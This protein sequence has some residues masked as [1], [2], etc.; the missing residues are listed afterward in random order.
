MKP[1]SRTINE[2]IDLGYEVHVRHA[3]EAAAPSEIV[4][5]GIGVGDVLASRLRRTGAT[6]T[7]VP[8]P[9]ARVSAD[10]HT[11]ALAKCRA[12]VVRS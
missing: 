12:A 8:Q 5:I 3:V 4:C 10:E 9:N 1:T 2:A 7:V 6:I 11:E